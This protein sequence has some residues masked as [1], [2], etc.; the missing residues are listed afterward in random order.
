MAANKDTAKESNGIFD[1]LDTTDKIGGQTRSGGG[2]SRKRRG[3][4]YGTGW[5]R[6]FGRGVVRNDG[7][8]GN[9]TFELEKR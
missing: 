2:L 8:A 1:V 3:G 4:A 7:S 9:Q 6:T 5:R